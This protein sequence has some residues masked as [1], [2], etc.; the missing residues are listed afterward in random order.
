MRGLTLA[1]VLLTAGISGAKV[2]PGDSKRGGELI[3]SQGCVNCH[4]IGGEGGGAGPDLGKPRGRNYTPSSMASTMWNHAPAMWSAMDKMGSPKPLMTESQA[5]DLF[6]YFQ[7]IRYFDKPGDAAR[8]KRVFASSRC[9]ECHGRSAALFG[10]APP[11]ASW[12]GASSPILFAQQMWNHFPQM[13]AAMTR[14]KLKWTPLTSQE[15]TDILVYVQ[16]LPETRGMAREFAL[17]AAGRGEALFTEKGCQGCHQ[18]SLDLNKRRLTG[19]VTD[20]A[21]AMW[22]HAPAMR[23]VGKRFGKPFPVLEADEM[24]DLMSYLWDRQIYGERGNAARGGRVF[25]KKQCLS[26]HAAGGTGPDLKARAAG[27]LM[28]F[29]M[30]SVLWR[31][32]PAMLEGMKSKQTPWPLFNETEMLDLV[33]YL[34]ALGS[35]SGKT[36]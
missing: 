32:G 30:V 31:H 9:G 18:G 1:A 25:E 24:R 35:G 21:V 12:K 20:F 14:R 17:A 7:S 26:C 29:S 11:I 6:A 4:R 8:G 22:N 23:A 3:R 13:D 10:G 16:A 5:G 36:D 28:A 34:S 19:T 33:A 15:L 27:P 2:I